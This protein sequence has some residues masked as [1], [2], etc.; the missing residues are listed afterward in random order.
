MTVM[1]SRFKVNF[2]VFLFLD[3]FSRSFKWFYN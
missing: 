1:D 2:A 3:G